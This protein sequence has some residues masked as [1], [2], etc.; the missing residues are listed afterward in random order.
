MT[1]KPW[2]AT[3]APVGTASATGQVISP[4]C[5]ITI[6]DGASLRGPYGVRIGTLTE[7]S[8]RNG[9]LVASGDLDPGQ[10][11]PDGT[12][13]TFDGSSGSRRIFGPVDSDDGQVSGGIVF[14]HILGLDR[15]QAALRSEKPRWDDREIRF[16]NGWCLHLKHM[17]DLI[18]FPSRELAELKRDE[19]TT[20]WETYR[21]E[22][23]KE[24]VTL[25]ESVAEVKPWPYDQISFA[26]ALEDLRADDPDG[27]LSFTSPE[28]QGILKTQ[29]S[30][31]AKALE[32]L[33]PSP[34]E[35]LDD[36]HTGNPDRLSL[37]SDSAGTTARVENPDL[38]EIAFRLGE[39][40]A[41]ISEADRNLFIDTHAITIRIWDS[42]SEEDR[43]LLTKAQIALVRLL[44]AR[45]I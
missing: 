42:I 16:T 38:A 21:K 24:G 8:L 32:Q 34:A 43:D 26:E 3:L 4:N 37:L 2:I 28:A 36:L 29:S 5:K 14:F 45:M 9:Y 31:V 33:R 12:T 17:G 25:P 41:A 19:F 22:R 44:D 35:T 13:P 15:V 30:T 39:H 6:R 11:I 18:P 1:Q 27:W 10:E 23:A 20:W 7:A 40:W